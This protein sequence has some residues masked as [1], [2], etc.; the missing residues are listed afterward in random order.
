MLKVNNLLLTVP[1]LLATTLEPQHVFSA[2]MV[3]LQPL[4]LLV[5][6]HAIAWLT[7][8]ELLIPQPPIPPR[9][10]SRTRHL[11]HRA[12]CAPVLQRL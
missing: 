11:E 8:M 10:Q 12:L 4:D 7:T 6:S 2:L 5:L 1:V 9:K 3:L